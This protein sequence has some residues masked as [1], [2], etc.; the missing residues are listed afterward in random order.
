MIEALEAL[1]LQLGISSQNLLMLGIG[2]GVVLM[3]IG[4]AS[5]FGERNTVADRIAATASNRR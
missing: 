2:I 4:V 1:S 3:F 5:F